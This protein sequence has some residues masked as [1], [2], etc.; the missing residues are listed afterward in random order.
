MLDRHVYLGPYV[1]VTQ[2]VT[3][4]S[5]DPCK[6][7][8]ISLG[9]N[10]CSTCGRSIVGRFTVERR[11]KAPAGWEENYPKGEFANFLCGVFVRQRSDEQME[12]FLPNRHYTQLGLRDINDDGDSTYPIDSASI[13][14]TVQKFHDLFKDELAYLQ[15][16]FKVE[17]LFG[18]V[19]Y[20]R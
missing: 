6:E 11:I 17:V 10:F 1:Q 14:T 5:T 16:W 3:E 15:Q 20:Y 19:T 12:V 13:P 18:V 2:Q 8:T 7:H 9:A 4:V